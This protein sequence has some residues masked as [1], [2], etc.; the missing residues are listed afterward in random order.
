MEEDV[1]MLVG[2]KQAPAVLGWGILA[3]QLPSD[4]RIV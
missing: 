1:V 3:E 4:M 2:T